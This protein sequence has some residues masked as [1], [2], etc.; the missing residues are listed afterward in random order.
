MLEIEDASDARQVDPPVRDQLGDAPQAKE[1]VVAVAAC[2]AAGA[3]R[4]YQA[5]LLVET[6]RL[7]AE[8]G[9]LG[10]TVMP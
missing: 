2:S 6:Q 5:V 4:V 9:E 8:P 7:G 10:R 1:V 3:G